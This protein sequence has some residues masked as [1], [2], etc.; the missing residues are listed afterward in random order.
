VLQCNWWRPVAR[1]VSDVTVTS[2]ELVTLLSWSSR[3][4]QCA[5][6]C[7]LGCKAWPQLLQLIT[8]WC[9]SAGAGTHADSLR[10]AA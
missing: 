9:V 8:C 6:S 4:L 3:K 1:A 10:A 5:A 2:S 7:E